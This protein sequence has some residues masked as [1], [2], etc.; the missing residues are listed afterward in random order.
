MTAHVVPENS[1]IVRTTTAATSGP[2]ARAK[3]R[4]PLALSA[5]RLG[6]RVL[7]PTVPALAAAYAERLFLTAPRHRRPA[8]EQAVLATAEPFQIPHGRSFLPAWRWGSGASPVLLVHGWEGRGSQLGA[9]VEPLLARGLSV[10]AFDAPGHGDAPA[11]TAS[12]VEHGRAVASAGAHLGRLHGVIGH[13]VGGAAA[14][15]ATRLGLRVDRLAL[16]SP[17]VNPDRFSAG[18]ARLFDLPADVHRAML[19]RLESRYGVRIDELDVRADAERLI[20]P[21]L[22]VHDAADRVVPAG[23]GAILAGSAPHGRLVTTEGLGHTR[24]LRAAEVLDAVVPFMAQGARAPSFAATLEGDLY[25]R[26][27]R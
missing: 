23:D 15:Y 26:Y 10:V 1:T 13:S 22:V 6:L 12:L 7:A 25:F 21:L 16:V 8:W 24:V 9:F 17:P 2:R 20:A 5:A 18:F 11:R 27:A 14:L 19:A 3:R 4:P